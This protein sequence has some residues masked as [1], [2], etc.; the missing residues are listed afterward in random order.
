[1]DPRAGSQSDLGVIVASARELHG[2]GL[3]IVSCAQGPGHG[4]PMD[5][6]RRHWKDRAMTW[7]REVIEISA[8]ADAVTYSGVGHVD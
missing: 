2:S 6:R 5:R 3:T 4:I 8:A 7:Y 1:M